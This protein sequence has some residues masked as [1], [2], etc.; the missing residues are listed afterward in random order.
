MIVVSQQIGAKKIGDGSKEIIILDICNTSIKSFRYQRASF[1][2]VITLAFY[3]S[4]VA[5]GTAG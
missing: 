2:T 1:S 5:E 3:N 4:N